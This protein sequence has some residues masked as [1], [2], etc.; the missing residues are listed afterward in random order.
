MK[1]CL[2]IANGQLPKKKDIN[3]LVKIGYSKIICAD[4]GANSAFR[5]N[6]VPDLIIGDLD[7]ISQN[8]FD[9]Y[10]DKSEIKKIERQNDTDV[11]KALKYAISKKY[12]EVILL[13][14][15]GDRLDH[16]FCNLGIALKFDDKIKVM[17]LHEKSFLMV[18][19]DEIDFKTSINE[20][21]SIYG[22]D[23]K[24]KVSS[25]GLKYELNKTSL[26]FG[27]RESTS[28]EALGNSVKIKTENGKIF[29]IRE[30]EALKKNDFF[31]NS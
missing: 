12:K 29:V 2:I 6:L 28:N 14:A 24:T 16:S 26:Q 27:V 1:K 22:F 4:G 15:T 21:I 19:K 8:I 10:S 13:G 17:I 11:E 7:S 3:Y 9:F 5:L 20:T 25:K 31:I 23:E 30:F 18:V